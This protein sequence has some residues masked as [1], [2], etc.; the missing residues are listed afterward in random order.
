MKIEL[1]QYQENPDGSADFHVDMDKEAVH[2]LLNYALLDMLTKAIETGSLYSPEFNSSEEEAVDENYYYDE[3]E[4]V[5]WYYVEEEDAWYYY[6]E[7]TE[8]WCIDEDETYAYTDSDV[9]DDNKKWVSLEPEQMDSLFVDEL[10]SC[11]VNTHFNTST[12]ED[13][14][15]MTN[16]VRKACKELLRYYMIPHEAENYLAKIE[17]MYER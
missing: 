15:E 14:I 13:D 6:D 17:A 1:T 2:C 12:H 11:F 7:E 8:E 9:A 3:E 5:E 4:G 16:N 10:K